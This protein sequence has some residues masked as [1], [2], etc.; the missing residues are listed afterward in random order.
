MNILSCPPFLLPL[1]FLACNGDRARSGKQGT[2]SN[3]LLFVPVVIFIPSPTQSLASDLLSRNCRLLSGDDSSD[4]I[5]DDSDANDVVVDPP[6][7]RMG[8]IGVLSEPTSFVAG[9]I[10]VLSC[11]TSCWQENPTTN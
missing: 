7:R 9:N 1:S 8:L 11:I 10:L 5:G 4:D 2:K 3:K 6:V